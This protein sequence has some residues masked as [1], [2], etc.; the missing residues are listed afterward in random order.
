MRRLIARARREN[1]RR[2][3]RI[4]A[5]AGTFLGIGVE[6]RREP[7]GDLALVQ[8]DLRGLGPLGRFFPFGQPREQPAFCPLRAQDRRGEHSGPGPAQPGERL[9]LTPRTL[10]LGPVGAL[11]T[12]DQFG[13]GSV[14]QR[15]DPRIV[16]RFGQ[17]QRVGEPLGGRHHE[18]RGMDEGVKLQQ[19]EP[20]KVG[21]A[22][23][24]RHQRGV[25]Q[26]KGRIGR[27]HDRLALADGASNPAFAQPHSA[28]TGMDRGKGE[29]GGHP[30]AIERNWNVPQAEL[31]VAIACASVAR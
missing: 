31:T 29:G 20:R 27:E 22:Q 16:R 17:S 9:Q 19:V 5:L 12:R 2:A 8:H 15:R 21:I 10:A 18:P 7:R 23:P 6:Q 13:S 30:A 14:E 28:V 3:A 25:E 11:A 24:V 4:V 26:Q 1:L